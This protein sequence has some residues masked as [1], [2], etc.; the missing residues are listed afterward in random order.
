MIYICNIIV[1]YTSTGT[2]LLKYASCKHKVEWQQIL[3]HEDGY[4]SMKVLLD[5]VHVAESNPMYDAHKE[6]LI[7]ETSLVLC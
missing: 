1:T 2:T 7:T 4:R 3:L 5:K 6:N